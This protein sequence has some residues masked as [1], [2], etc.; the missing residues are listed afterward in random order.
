MIFENENN[1]KKLDSVGRLVIPKTIRYKAGIPEGGDI[2][3]YYMEKDGRKYICLTNA[4]VEKVEEKYKLAAE[5]LRE[6][7][8]PVPESLSNLID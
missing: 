1:V 5:V 7:G 3:F 4:V 2:S 6:L 8:E